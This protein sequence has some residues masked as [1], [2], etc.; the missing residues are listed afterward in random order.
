L[1]SEPSL[2]SE[3][4]NLPVEAGRGN[5]AHEW[6][7]ATVYYP[8]ARD[9]AGASKIAV[10]P[11]ATVQ[12]NMTLAREAFQ[13]VTAIA[14]LPQAIAGRNFDFAV[15]VM[16]ISGRALPYPARFGSNAKMIQASLPDGSYRLAVT[17]SPNGPGFVPDGGIR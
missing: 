6:G 14:V 13:T 12:A 1:N 8:D 4:L 11:G 10:E 3:N 2:D 17:T 5:A 9:P 15:Q 16:D 7:F